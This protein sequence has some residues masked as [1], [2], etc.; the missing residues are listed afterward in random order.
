MRVE[1]LAG[2]SGGTL[3]G[4]PC[5]CNGALS[6]LSEASVRKSF[7]EKSTGGLFAVRFVLR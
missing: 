5:S 2:V 4:T 6:N 1:P 7:P 3:I